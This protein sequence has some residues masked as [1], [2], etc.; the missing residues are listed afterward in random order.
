MAP[1]EIIAAPFET[2][3]AVPGTAFPVIN[4][5]PA[6]AWARLG[7]AGNRNISEDGITV[8]HAEEIETFTPLGLT[9]PVKAWRVSE[10]LELSFMLHDM[11]IEQYIAVLNMGTIT[12]TAAG[13]G[14]AGHRAANLY[15]GTG[16]PPVRAVLLRGP[17]PYGDG[18]NMQY[19]IRRAIIRAE[20]EVNFRRDEPAGLQITLTALVDTT[21]PAGQELGILRMQHAAPL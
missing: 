9:A 12:T 4:A 6:G 1:F 8:T 7:T 3:I 18:W 21:A 11:T 5:A 15:K 16:S 2:W 10:G 13:A 17:G 14:T 20:A 19:E